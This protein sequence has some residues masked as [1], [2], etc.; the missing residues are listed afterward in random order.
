MEV[1]MKTTLLCLKVFFQTPLGKVAKQ[2]ERWDGKA[3]HPKQRQVH[4]ARVAL[5]AGTFESPSFPH[6]NCK[7]GE[8]QFVVRHVVNKELLAFRNWPR[9]SRSHDVLRLHVTNDVDF[10][11][12]VT[13]MIEI[14]SFWKNAHSWSALVLDIP[15]VVVDDEW[16]FLKLPCRKLISA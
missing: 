12:V 3:N 10:D 1:A 5:G 15:A 11:I 2:E 7:P 13:R 6:L 14:R 9:G 4:H 16:K 8:R